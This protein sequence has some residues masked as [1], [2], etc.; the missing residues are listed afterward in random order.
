M[1]KQ[2]ACFQSVNAAVQVSNIKPG[3]PISSNERLQPFCTFKLPQQFFAADVCSRVFWRQTASELRVLHA[4]PV[5]GARTLGGAH[6]S[7]RNLR[8]VE[9][10]SGSDCAK[11]FA[12]QKL[13]PVRIA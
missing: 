6:N 12:G 5:C 9:M 1:R 4:A 11:V 8:A 13:V 3:E 7:E 2:F 10:M